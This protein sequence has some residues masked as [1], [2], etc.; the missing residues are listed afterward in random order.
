[1][2]Q[3]PGGVCLL[4]HTHSWDQAGGSC[5]AA[6]LRIQASRSRPET[7]AARLQR[8]Y[9]RLAT[10]AHNRADFKFMRSAVLAATLTAAIPGPISLYLPT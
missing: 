6:R 3:G 10:C 5:A 8:T 1:M 7:L 4:R 2:Q 9:C